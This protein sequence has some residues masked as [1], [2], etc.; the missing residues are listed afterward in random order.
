MAEI[1]R[2]KNLATKFQILVEIAAN[3]PNIQQREI[4]SKLD[5]TPQ[6]VSEYVLKMEDDGWVS[7]EGRSRYR[8]TQEGVNWVLKSLRELEEYTSF[9]RKAMTNVTISAA[10]ADCD[11]SEG[12]P[13]GLIMRDGLLFATRNVGDK[14]RGIAVNDAKKGEDVGISKIEGVV[15]LQRGKITL[16]RVPDIQGGGSGSANVVLLK[17]IVSR[18]GLVGAVGIEAL[19]ALRRGGIEPNYFYGVT[20]AAIEASHTGLSYLIVCVE[21][22]IP[23]VVRKLEDAGSDYELWDM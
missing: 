16:L 11:L 22:A 12:Q 17:N 14:A 6:A 4:A 23:D 18:E 9:V 2:N 13:V 7:S 19:I 3:Q 10:V 8:V 21:D 5:V 1:L 20:E 15:E